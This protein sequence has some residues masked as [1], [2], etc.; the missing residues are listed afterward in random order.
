M[1]L[2]LRVSLLPWEGSLLLPAV[3]QWQGVAGRVKHM[4]P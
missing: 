3:R 1:L 2:H 4:A